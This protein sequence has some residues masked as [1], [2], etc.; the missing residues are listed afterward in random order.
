MDSRTRTHR[1]HSRRADDADAFLPDPDGGVSYAGDELAQELVD[2]FLRSVT[3][4]DDAGEEM[5]DH[6]TPDECGG[7]FLIRS[8]RSIFVRGSDESNP[9]DGSR[10]ALPSPMRAR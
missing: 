5:M 10:E 9:V 8:G 2:E 6:E 3:S 1:D 4:G 7:P